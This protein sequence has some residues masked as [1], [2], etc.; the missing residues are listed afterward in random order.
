MI[1]QST[2][3]LLVDRIEPSEEFFT[4]LGFERTVEVPE[5][6]GAKAAA[7]FGNGQLAIRL[8]RG[9]G[10]ATETLVVHPD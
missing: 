5:G 7:T 8:E 3:L 1:L 2:P 6:C 4:K 10:T 9:E